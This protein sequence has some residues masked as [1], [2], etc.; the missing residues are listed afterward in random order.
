MGVA[1]GRAPDVY[2][3]GY[4]HTPAGQGRPENASLAR[5]PVP[6][7]IQQL[8]DFKSG[9]R[10]SASPGPYPPPELMIRVAMYATADEVASA[11]EYFSQ[12]KLKSHVL[13]LERSRVPRSHVVGLVYAAIPGA[14]QE[15]LGVRLLEFAPDATRHE[16]RD[17][18]LQYV[19]YAPI[20][21]CR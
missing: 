15:P 6:Y 19:A 13:V 17:E 18:D 1:R 14:P 9:V 3:C 11:A 16:N 21:R 7:I 20:G 10:R 4:C 2:A 12:Q 8:A 5:L